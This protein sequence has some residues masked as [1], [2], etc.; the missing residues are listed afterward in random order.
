MRSETGTAT[1]SAGW[2]LNVLSTEQV[3]YS[4]YLTVWF[5]VL[6]IMHAQQHLTAYDDS[7]PTAVCP[8]AN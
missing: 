5:V 7:S 2:V 4:L 8:V 3:R 6:F 1:S